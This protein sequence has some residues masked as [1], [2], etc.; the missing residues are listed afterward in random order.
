MKLWLDFL[1]ALF[2]PKD[3][4]IKTVICKRH[5]IKAFVADTYFKKGFGLMYHK[6]LKE[7]EGMLFIF[8]D[9]SRPGIWMYNMKFPIDVAW[10]DKSGKIVHAVKNAQP[11]KS[12]F[13]SEI[14]KAE[15]ASEYVL[16]LSAGKIARME[17]RIGDRIRIL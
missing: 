16:E 5:R 13:N 4:K 2:A 17:V 12:I 11:R 7:N 6:P 8:N 10:I 9:N 1:H 3:Y 15:K 14:Y